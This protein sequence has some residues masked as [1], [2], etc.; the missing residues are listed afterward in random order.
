MKKK[1]ELSFKWLYFLVYS[2]LPLIIYF[3]VGTLMFLNKVFI[4][5]S[6]TLPHEAEFTAGGCI[7]EEPYIFYNMSAGLIFLTILFQIF[8]LYLAISFTLNIINV[9]KRTKRNYYYLVKTIALESFLLSFYLFIIFRNLCECF[10]LYLF[11]TIIPGIIWFI[12]NFI[13]LKK[14]KNFYFANEI[15]KGRKELLKKEVSY[16]WLYFSVYSKIP[17]IIFAILKIGAFVISALI[18]SRGHENICH[19]IG[20]LSEEQQFFCQTSL[21]SIVLST[22]VNLILFGS[23]CI[24]IINIINVKKRNKKAYR[25]LIV[26]LVMETIMMVLF[27]WQWLDIVFDFAFSSLVITLIGGIIWFVIN[28]IYLKKRKKV[29]YLNK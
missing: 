3:F 11:F 8:L 5:T 26:A 4:K 6:T 15:E 12:V 23:A 27:Y 20:N 17:L 1:K 25:L 7:V 18:T 14:R 13:Y 29:Y 9:K 19:L 24:F 2:K 10:S 22:V 28:Y 16:K 21:I